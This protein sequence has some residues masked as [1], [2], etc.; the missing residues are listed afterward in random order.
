[1]TTTH[2]ILKSHRHS[3]WLPSF[4]YFSSSWNMQG[5]KDKDVNEMI[6]IF[7]MKIN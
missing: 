7:Q 4:C 1:M 3:F 5:T 6:T 2:G